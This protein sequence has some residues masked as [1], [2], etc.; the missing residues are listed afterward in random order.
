MVKPTLLTTVLGGILLV[1]SV[2]ALGQSRCIAFP[3][4]DRSLVPN[5]D[6]PQRRGIVEDAGH[7]VLDALEALSGTTNGYGGGGHGGGQHPEHPPQAP[8]PPHRGSHGFILASSAH[9]YAA[10]I[11]LDSSDDYAIHIAAGS[12]AKDIE[13]VTGVRPRVYNDTL[14]KGTTKAVLVGSAGSGLVGG[15]GLEHVRELEGKWEAFD[16]RVVQRVRGL[17]EAL[18]ISGSDRVSTG[19][20][21]RHDSHHAPLSGW[22]SLHRVLLWCMVPPDL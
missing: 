8:H 6:G 9:H 13:R 10:P 15:I 16:A 2:L 12:F 3:G 7:L 17:E 22:G 20:R 11:L 18:V 5:S 1:P 4:N 21:L 19:S 14:P